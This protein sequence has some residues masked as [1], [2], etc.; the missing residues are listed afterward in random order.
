MRQFHTFAP[1]FDASSRVLILGSFPSVRSREEGFYYGHPRNRFWKVISELLCEP[2]PL[3]I[4]EKRE[5]LLKSR[6]ALWDVC[7]SC[8]ITGSSDATI[9][10]V[11]PN[12]LSLLLTT[13]KISLICTNGRTADKLYRR[14]VRNID[15]PERCL[16]STSPANAAWT[17]DRLISEWNIIKEVICNDQHQFENRG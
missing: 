1:V 3:T 14:F 10:K 8:E 4:P 17:V 11:V 2:L 9:S 12:D 15:I 5:L 16:P 6:I 13:A 7:S